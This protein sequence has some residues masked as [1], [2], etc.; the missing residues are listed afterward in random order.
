MVK[1]HLFHNIALRSKVLI[2]NLKAVKYVD[3]KMFH[4]HFYLICNPAVSLPFFIINRNFG[5]AE[6]A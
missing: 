5:V 1:N 2:L 4:G 3:Y 6:V